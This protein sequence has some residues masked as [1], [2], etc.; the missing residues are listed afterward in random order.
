MIMYFI[1]KPRIGIFDNL[2]L[3]EQ[4]YKIL[5]INKYNN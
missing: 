5:E 1:Y 3:D 2:L 4:K